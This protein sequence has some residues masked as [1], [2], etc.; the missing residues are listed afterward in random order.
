GIATVAKTG[1]T[2]AQTDMPFTASGRDAD[3]N[4]GKA[5]D[6]P[7]EKETQ[8]IKSVP[9][10]NP[11]WANHFD[12]RV[13]EETRI[14]MENTKDEAITVEVVI[15]LAGEIKTE[16]AQIVKLPRRYGERNTK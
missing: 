13:T 7:M 4:L 12:S 6:V 9:V 3:L 11:T 15:L 14:S 1:L 16:G 2:L 5:P 8:E 10:P